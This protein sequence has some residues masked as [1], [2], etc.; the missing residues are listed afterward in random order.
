MGAPIQR[1][2]LRGEHNDHDDA[3]LKLPD[4]HQRYQDAFASLAPA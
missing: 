1:I 3:M 2:D 4:K